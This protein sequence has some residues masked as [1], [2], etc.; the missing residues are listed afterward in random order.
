MAATCVREAAR[1]ME[2]TF[3]FVSAAAAAA[4]C[5][6]PTA[7][8]TSRVVFTSMSA[9]VDDHVQGLTTGHARRAWELLS[10]GAAIQTLGSA[11]SPPLAGAAEHR[12]G[13]EH[14]GEC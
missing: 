10:A 14:C 6:M 8:L 11:T 2:G 7:A 3:S 12:G 13:D 4:S 9:D 5:A 1:H